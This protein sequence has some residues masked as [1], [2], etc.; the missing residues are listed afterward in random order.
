MAQFE[1]E[2]GHAEEGEEREEEDEEDDH[3]AL[4]VRACAGKREGERVCVCV[5]AQSA[6]REKERGV[7]CG[8]AAAAAA[9]TIC[10]AATNI[11]CTNTL[12]P[13]IRCMERSGLSIR[14]NRRVPTTGKSE[15]TRVIMPLM[16]T[17]ISIQFQPLSR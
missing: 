9:R 11:H 16:T 6:A 15:K 17:I 3:V 14:T 1:P 5:R 13:R 7:R 4:C 12:M 10:G 8:A 2:E